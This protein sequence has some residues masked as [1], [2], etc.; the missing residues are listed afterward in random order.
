MAK[1]YLF[2]GPSGSGK[3]TQVEMLQKEFLVERIATGEMFRK[4]YEQGDADAIEAHRAW[5]GG[6]FV[7]DDLTYKMLSKWV[8]QFDGDKDWIFLSVVRS[9]GQI[10][11]FDELLKAKGRSLDG[12][13][14]FSLSNEAAIERLSLRRICPNCQATFHP[15]YKKEKIEGICDLC[16]TKLVQREDDKEEKIISRLEEYKRTINPILEEYKK[17]GILIEIDA[18]P[19]IEVIFNDLKGKIELS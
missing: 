13:V 3:D 12:V 2:H 4:L 10:L 8:D 7:G 17:R 6:K 9:L 1:T 19:S 16:G 14:H 11:M 15:K 18:S 5:G